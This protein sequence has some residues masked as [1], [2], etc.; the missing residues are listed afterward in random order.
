DLAYV[1]SNA[2]SMLNRTLHVRVLDPEES[3]DPVTS[4]LPEKMYWQIFRN[5]LIDYIARMMWESRVFSDVSAETDDEPLANPD[6][7][8]EVAV[9]QYHIGSGWKRYL[10]G[11]GA[12]ATAV[13]WEGRIFDAR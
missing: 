12:G 10:I 6:L 8:L 1:S 11:F 7:I 3:I 2:P 9:T 5:A 4:K 13:Q